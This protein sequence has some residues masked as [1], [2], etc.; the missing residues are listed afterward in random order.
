L[1]ALGAVLVLAACGGD[2]PAGGETQILPPL[3]L[4][5]A[6]P[7]CEP[8]VEAVRATYE[9]ARA[10]RPAPDDPRYG[11][12]VVVAG[13][14]DM[15]GGLN[16]LTTGDQQT[17]ETELH[18][19]HV[20]LLTFDAE[21]NPQPYLASSWTIDDDFGGA[22]IQLRDDLRWHDGRPVTAED[23]AFT[24]RAVMDPGTEFSNA[25]WFAFYDAEAI[26]ALDE[27]TV[28]FEFEPHASILDPWGSLSIM[29]AHLLADV[30][31]DRETLL[32]HP[33]STECP[34][35]AGP[36]LFESYQPGSEW[37]LRA[38]PDFPED[39]GGT[40]FIDR[41]IYRV[42]TSSA[43]RAGELEA[44][45][46]DVAL[47]LEP[48]DGARI[49]AAE[50]LNLEEYEQRG[51]SFISWNPLLPGLD[52]ARVRTALTMGIDRPTLVRTLRDRFGVVAETGV[53]AFHYAHDPTLTGPAY[54]PDGARALLDDAGWSDRD[55]DGVREN[56]AGTP[57]AIEII[58]N[59]NN[60]RE[61]IG[62]IVRDQL[63][64]IG[65][66]IELSVLE[67]GNM[68]S[69]VITPGARDFGGLILGWAPDYTAY[70]RSF[71]HSEA[72]A[73]PL[74]W[75]SLED[76]ELDRLL[77]T[78]PRIVDPEEARPLWREYQQ[79]IIDLQPFTYLFY[80]RRL[81]GVRS[82]LRGYVFD[83]RGD[84]MTAPGWYWDPESN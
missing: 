35:G 31:R 53:G 40:P 17:Q 43:T 28:R 13:G 57:L 50:G 61:G 37:V 76:P 65:V 80:S 48:V 15:I 81:N 60:E 77:D 33:F 14:A 8:V 75:S 84:L 3:A 27:T 78:L 73:V 63:T 51:F 23:V 4:E 62:R 20:T 64:E 30:P 21:R 41:Y 2:A 11:G 9:T 1:A 46:V 39:L 7:F 74:G 68:Q 67:M 24:Y 59:A 49:E 72:R 54:D 69:R 34:V 56:A 6:V 70:E 12:T 79:R 47:G 32:Q 16:G 26:E 58:T 18:L 29:P 45:G 5:S 25:S 22:T 42:I 44:G 10:L 36:Y 19:F 38:N 83:T 52:D 66:R 55:G 71:F 82:S